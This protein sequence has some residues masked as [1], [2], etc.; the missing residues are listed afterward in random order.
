MSWRTLQPSATSPPIHP[1]GSFPEP[2]KYPLKPKPQTPKLPYTLNF[3]KLTCSW[4]LNVFSCAIQSRVYGD[5]V[6]Y[7]VSI[8]TIECKV[9]REVM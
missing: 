5:L 2:S 6:L 3:F 4:E 9:E 8:L 7:E 1:G